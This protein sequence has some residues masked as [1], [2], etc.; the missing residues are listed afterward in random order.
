MCVT[1]Q[2]WSNLARRAWDE[3]FR[4]ADILRSVKFAVPSNLHFAI[5]GVLV[6]A[7]AQSPSQVADELRRLA[8]PCE[9]Q[10]SGQPRVEL[11]T[12]RSN[13]MLGAAQRLEPLRS[14]TAII[15][16]YQEILQ[17]LDSQANAG[18]RYL[19]MLDSVM[20]DWTAM[21]H[22]GQESWDTM[23]AQHQAAQARIDQMRLDILSGTPFM[24]VYVP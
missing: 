9:N 2:H 5:D 24:K 4:A 20:P 18:L 19:R 22:E 10:L 13:M 14:N 12:R 23:W 3:V 7:L 11:L 8:E 17:T 15:L 21:M 1:C 16:Q 6:A